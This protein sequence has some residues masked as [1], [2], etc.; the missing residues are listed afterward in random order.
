MPERRSAAP[1][2][3]RVQVLDDAYVLCATARSSRSG[4]CATCRRST[5]TSRSST[6]RGLCAIPGLV[7][8]HTH[9][10]WGGDRV[11]EFSLRAARR[12]L[13]G[14]AR[15]R[16]RDPLDRP[17]DARARRGRPPC[18][19]R[20]ARRLDAR[21][22]HDDL[23]G[24]VGLR[25]RSRDR[26]RVA[27]GGPCRRRLT[28]LARRALGAARVRRRR[29]L[30]RLRARGGAAGGRRSSPTRPMSSS[31]A[32]RST[33]RRRGAT[34][35]ACACRRP[36]AAPPRRPV[37]RERR[38]P[39]GGRARAHG[40]STTSRRPAPTGR[41]Q[42]AA[43]EVTGVLLPGER[44]LPRPADAACAS[45]RRCRRGDRARHRLQP[46]QLVHDEPAA[47]LL[48]RLHPAEARTRRGACRGHRQRGPR[49]RLRRRPRPHRSRACGPT[50]SCSTRPTGATSPTTSP[51]TSSRRSFAAGRVAYRR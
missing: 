6:G 37:H 8:C 36:R 27:A 29:R 9:P 26:A 24:Q 15:G 45:A 13:R 46:G 40:R 5:A 21:P 22:R 19:R 10:A 47:R 11:E 28:D 17:R 1:N 30:P 38:D 50:S 39:A 18:A 43:S 51:A 34:S 12:E 42:L 2:S 31:S 16:R 49:A 14:A 48:A 3:G 41:V 7:D 33:P 32:A 44:P 35:T 25:A 20:A 23:G 4:A